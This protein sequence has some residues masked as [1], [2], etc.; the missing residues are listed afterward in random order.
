LTNA[1]F[2]GDGQATA[3]L[4]QP[5][6][7]LVLQP[8]AR[9]VPVASEGLV[10]RQAFPRSSPLLA[11]RPHR[12][13]R[14]LNLEASYDPTKREPTIR[15]TLIPELTHPAGRA[16]PSGTC[17]RQDSYQKGAGTT[18]DFARPPGHLWRF[19]ASEVSVGALT[20]REALRGR[21]L[22]R[23]SSSLSSKAGDASG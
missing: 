20:G 5:G 4:N 1:L 3:S 18:C 19:R 13:S 21:K 8:C 11:I 15:V 14:R 22:S 9:V 10:A 2:L 23:V 6:M 12:S 17:P 7:E 16:L